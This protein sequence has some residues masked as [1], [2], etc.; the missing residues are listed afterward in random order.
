LQIINFAFQ[1]CDG[2]IDCED[3]T[4]EKLCCDKKSEFQCAVTKK[5]ISLAKVC[6]KE[7]DCADSSDEL[8]PECEP[9]KNL[10]RVGTGSEAATATTSTYLIAIFAALIS[11]FLLSVVVYYCKRR[12]GGG[13]LSSEDRDATC[14]LATRPSAEPNEHTTATLLL[15]ERGRPAGF[16][17][18]AVAGNAAA[19]ANGLLSPVD[20]SSNGLL[21]DR[22]HVTGASSTAG[23][24]SSGHGGPSHGHPPSP[25]TSIGTRLSRIGPS[26]SAA[27]RHHHQLGKRTGSAFNVGMPTGYKYYTHR[28]APPCTPCSTDINDESDSLAYSVLP[29]RP[30]FPSRAGSV[31]PNGYDSET[32]CMESYSA[33]ELPS[34]QERGRYAPPPST[35]FYL[36]DY[37]DQETSGAPSPNTERSYFLNPSCLPGPPPSRVP[38]PVHNQSLDDS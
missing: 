10:A 32:Y 8:P 30:H 31:A 22:S 19:V 14:P 7:H 29:H 6:N 33:A 18:A 16:D 37:G 3:G 35:P 27:S 28:A 24:S 21:Y 12:A 20:G 1:V 17:A 11:V 26:S 25:A 38:S 5:C 15:A 36:S 13:N 2:V 34:L 9:D 23:T 4:D